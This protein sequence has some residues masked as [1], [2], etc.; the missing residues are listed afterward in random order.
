MTERC[1]WFFHTKRAG[2]LQ[3]RARAEAE[4]GTIGDA[5]FELGAAWAESMR[6]PWAEMLAAKRGVLVI[7]DSGARY[8]VRP[9]R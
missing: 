4:D 1:S 5:Q 2:V 7:I 6:L 8:E 3:V 9:A